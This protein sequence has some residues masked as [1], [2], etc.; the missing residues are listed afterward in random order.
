MN[1]LSVYLSDAWEQEQL[2]G[3]RTCS[4][5]TITHQACNHW[6]LNSSVQMNLKDCFIYLYPNLNNKYITKCISCRKTFKGTV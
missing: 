1:Y 4:L 6:G 5:V 2:Q 3:S